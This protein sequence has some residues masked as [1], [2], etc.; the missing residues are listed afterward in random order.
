MPHH[1][2]KDNNNDDDDGTAVVDVLRRPKVGADMPDG[3]PAWF[4]VP[5]PS[6]GTFH[7][8]CVCVCVCVCAATLFLSV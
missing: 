3:R 4:K 1:V 6:Q 5:A 8:L 7:D 2:K